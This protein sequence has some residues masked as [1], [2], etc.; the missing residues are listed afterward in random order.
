[1][2]LLDYYW[3][4]M[5]PQRTAHSAQHPSVSRFP[6]PVSSF[7]LGLFVLAPSLSV[8]Q[9]VW[10]PSRVYASRGGL[11]SLA[12]RLELS[13][14]SPAYSTIL[15]SEARVQAG[16]LRTRLSN[17]DF[18]AGDRIVVVVERELAMSDSFTVQQGPMIQLPTVGRIELGGVLRSE[19]EEHLTREVGRYVRDPTVSARSFVR[20]LVEGEV[21]QAG[22]YSVP[23][24]GL[25]T[26]IV[27]L[28]GQVTATAD[29]GRIRIERGGRVFWDGG[30]LGPEIIEGRTIDQLGVQAGDRLIVGAK[31]RAFA[32]F[33]GGFRTLFYI[34]TLPATVLG[35]IALFSG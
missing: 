3:I 14:E 1:M 22:F 32:S 29:L 25:I 5:I 11:D 4:M 27:E 30:A 8:A 26:D 15:R 6:F 9:D 17:G 35:L 23:S 16:E 19:L 7:L 20:I 13:A 28:A 21:G 24:E 10:D 34:L 2:G 33:E 31:A 12:R 18:R